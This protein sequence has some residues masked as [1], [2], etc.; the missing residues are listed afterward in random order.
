MRVISKEQILGVE[1]G[2]GGFVIERGVLAGVVG[3]E[4]EGSGGESARGVDCRRI[5]GVGDERAGGGADAGLVARGGRGRRRGG[6][7]R[8]GASVGV[9][10][11]EPRGMSTSWVAPSRRM[12]SLREVRTEA[13]SGPV[14]TL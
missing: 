7:F 14:P 8:A 12:L 13:P 9:G 2:E 1:V 3:D 5:S 10:A 6:G 11:T 4:T